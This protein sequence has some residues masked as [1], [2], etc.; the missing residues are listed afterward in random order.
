MTRNEESDYVR[1]KH[2]GDAKRK[3]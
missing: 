2:I 1:V 3:K